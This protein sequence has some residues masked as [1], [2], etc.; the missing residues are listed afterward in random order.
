MDQLVVGVADLPTLPEA[1]DEV[2]LLGK[3]G[4]AQICAAELAG[5]AGTIP[6]EI[7][8]AIKAR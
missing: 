5:K 1:G 8:T 4:S 7:F 6:W 2:V 3:Q